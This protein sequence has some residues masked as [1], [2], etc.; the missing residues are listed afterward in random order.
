MTAAEEEIEQ[1]RVLLKRGAGIGTPDDVWTPYHG[2][3]EQEILSKAV[4]DF[5]FPDGVE[6]PKQLSPKQLRAGLQHYGAE[7]FIA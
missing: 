1:L 2:P 3:D 5:T 4:M 7:A 6:S